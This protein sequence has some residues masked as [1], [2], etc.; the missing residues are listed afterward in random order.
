MSQTG[1]KEILIV[2]LEEFADWEVSYVAAFLNSSEEY[3]TKTVGVSEG[4]I[5]SIGGVHVLPDYTLESVPENFYGLILIGGNSWRK[6]LNNNVIPLVE[7][8]LTRN[9][10]VG[11]ICDAT[12]FMGAN[13]WLNEIKHTSNDLNVLKNYAKENYRNEMNYVLEQAVTDGKI[14]TANGTASIEF[15]KEILNLLE[16]YPKEQINQLIDFHKLGYYEAIKINS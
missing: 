4:V 5:K 14:V 16:A 15:A 7:K 2:L 6:P 11:A 1:E 10:P 8:A 13:G 3:V 12:V 9:I